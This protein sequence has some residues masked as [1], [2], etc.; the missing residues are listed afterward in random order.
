MAEDRAYDTAR[1]PELSFPA[2]RGVFVPGDYHSSNSGV[3]V[4]W[5]ANKKVAEEMGSHAWQENHGM[6][7]HPKDRIVIHNAEI[8]LSS[9]ESDT[10]VL[11]KNRVLSPDNLN[12]NI[13]EE[14]PVKKGKTVRVKSTSTST[15]ARTRTRTYNPPREMKA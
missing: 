13:E 5:S 3:G 8:P 12:K 7:T 2:Y 6:G 14:V 15:R 11:K 1:Q 4:H 9:V 10:N